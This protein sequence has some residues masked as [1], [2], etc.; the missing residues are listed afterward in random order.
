MNKEHPN[1]LIDEADLRTA[2]QALRADPNSF[3]AGIQQRV[4]EAEIRLR[5][6]GESK[7]VR[8]DRSEWLRV[9]A[10][11]IPLPLLSKGGGGAL[12][13]LSLGQ[14]SLSKKIV[15]VAA[16]PA[17]GLLLMVTATIWAIIKIRRAQHGQPAGEI[18]ALK[19]GEITAG[20]WRQF[21]V[22]VVGMSGVLLLLMLTG[23]AIPVFMIFLVSGITMVSLVTRLG[24]E[25]L[26]DR[27]T[28]AGTMCP[29]LFMLVQLTQM[30]TMFNHGFPFLDQMLIPTVLVLGGFAMMVT[31][32]YP[33]EHVSRSTRL[34][35]K[36]S[37]GIGLLLMAGW[38]SSSL[39]NPV[40]TSDGRWVVPRYHSGCCSRV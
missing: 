13:K 28:I 36:S 11:V 1:K 7:D 5:Q 40:S 34:F 24:K 38:F 22:L 35:F 23:Y 19:V 17:I 9:A 6:D 25:R 37:L 12:V 16:L 21:G 27:N 33:G 18:D 39:W 8:L 10:V 15:A 32:V 29:G 31:C 26:V 4:Q 30:T 14:L 2:L 3:A 20:W